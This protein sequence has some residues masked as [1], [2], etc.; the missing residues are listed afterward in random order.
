MGNVADFKPESNTTFS[1]KILCGMSLCET[2]EY[3]H[4]RVQISMAVIMDDRYNI[5]SIYA[6]C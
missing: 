6:D 5:P 3:I 2:P 1:G 4:R